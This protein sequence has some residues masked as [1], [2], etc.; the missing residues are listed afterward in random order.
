MLRAPLR[1]LS[2]L[3]SS[4]PLL[5]ARSLGTDVEGQ[6]KNEAWKASSSLLPRAVFLGSAGAVTFAFY[7]LT[8]SLLSLTP[9][10]SLRWGFLGGVIS[11]AVVGSLVVGFDQFIHTR[12]DTTY[13][14]G[15]QLALG[16]SSLRDA[17]G[18]GLKVDPSPIKAYRS[19]QGYFNVLSLRTP[20]TELIFKVTGNR[21]T[22][23]VFVHSSHAVIFR[24]AHLLSCQADVHLPSGRTRLLL[25]GSEDNDRFNSLLSAAAP[26]LK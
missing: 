19:N 14:R 13:A 26:L 9:A 16:S 17:L 4:T 12:P 8:Y 7:E 18:G 3:R 23:T 2:L 5:G 24:K 11:S 22:A 6:K 21:G 10:L 1:R 25:G 20:A 15:L